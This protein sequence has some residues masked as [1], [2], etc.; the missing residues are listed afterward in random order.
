[1]VK[2]NMRNEAK[3]FPIIVFVGLNSWKYSYMKEDDT[4]DK[5]A[6]EI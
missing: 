2:G 1:M 3:D 5:E 4:G 6:K